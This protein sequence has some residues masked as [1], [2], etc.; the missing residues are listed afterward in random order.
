MMTGKPP[1]VGDQV[2]ALEFT[3]PCG[4]TCELK[5]I[6]KPNNFMAFQFTC[7]RA[8]AMTI[9]GEKALAAIEALPAPL[10]GSNAGNKSI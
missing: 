2:I 10:P 1:Q 9:V 7:G 8:Y 3:C 5:R 6:I 4:L